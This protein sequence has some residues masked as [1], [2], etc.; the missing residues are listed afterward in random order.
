MLLLYVLF[1]TYLLTLFS[2]RIIKGEFKSRVAG[3]A[4]LS[5]MLLLTGVGH[6][7]YP[8]MAMMIP[9]FIPYR[10]EII[11]LTGIIEFA[12]AIGLLI[13]KF[14]KTTAWLLIIFLVL[15]LPCNIYA[16]MNH[17]NFRTGALDGDGTDYLWFRIP[18]QI[19]L[20]GWTYYFGIYVDR[21]KSTVMAQS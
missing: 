1:G 21:E 4:G 11:Y 12:A 5:A 14:Q 3:R 6:F 18:M 15:I 17:I 8:D 19:F 7:L 10:L 20:I 2:S 13:P 9:D 16:A